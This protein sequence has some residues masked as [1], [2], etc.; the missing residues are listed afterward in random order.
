M[1]ITGEKVHF[2]GPDSISVKIEKA[3][4]EEKSIAEKYSKNGQILTGLSHVS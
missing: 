4:F 1:I 3:I 2:S